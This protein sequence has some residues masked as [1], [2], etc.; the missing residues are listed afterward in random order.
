MAESIG[1]GVTISL[2]DFTML[3]F[4]S[5]ARIVLFYIVIGLLQE[6]VQLV[7]MYVR[8]SACVHVRA[9]VNECVRVHTYVHTRRVDGCVHEHNAS[10]MHVLVMQCLHI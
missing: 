3:E 6:G 4:G 5:L 9:C 2:R 1:V 8:A 7:C 10:L